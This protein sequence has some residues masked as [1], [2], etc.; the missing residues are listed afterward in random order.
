[1]GMETE[2]LEKKISE[3]LK[4]FNRRRLH[5]AQNLTVLKLIRR[6]NP[7]LYK[8]LGIEIASELMANLLLP[9]PLCDRFQFRIS[10]TASLN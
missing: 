10:S 1:M 4:E 8:S 6:K 7:Y 5:A 9:L 2:E 3:C